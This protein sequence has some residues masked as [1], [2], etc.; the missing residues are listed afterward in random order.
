MEKIE[1]NDRCTLMQTPFQSQIW[2]VCLTR[3]E[4]NIITLAKQ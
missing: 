4:K 1:S 3:V 2:Q